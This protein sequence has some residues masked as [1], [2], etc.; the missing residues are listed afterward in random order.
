M[1]FLSPKVPTFDPNAAGAA[2]VSPPPPPSAPI[3]AQVAG[4]RDA[5]KKGLGGT[6]LTAGVNP[7]PMQGN[8]Q[9]GKTL[10]GQ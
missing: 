9:T 1:G 7:S 2:P 6:F 8:R 4:R 10:L 3:A 5:M